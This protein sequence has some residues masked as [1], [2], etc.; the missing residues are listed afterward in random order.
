MEA[1]QFYDAEQHMLESDDPNE[2]R[3]AEAILRERDAAHPDDALVQF[4][5][6]SAFDASDREADAMVHYRRAFKIGVDTLPPER[7]PELYLQAGSTLRNL[8]QLDEARDLLTE[9]VSVFP[10]FRALEAFLALVEVSAGNDSGAVNHLLALLTRD[11]E[12]DESLRHYRRAL[13]WYAQQIAEQTTKGP[14]G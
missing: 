10:E 6:A 5:I 4:L 8:G 12:G 11:D 3:Q 14:A 7:R 2:V 1:S 9:G 13:T